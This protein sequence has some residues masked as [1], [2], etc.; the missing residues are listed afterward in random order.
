MKNLVNYL[1]ESKTINKTNYTQFVKNKGMG[2]SLQDWYKKEYK[3]DDLGDKIPNISFAE[4]LAMFFNE[5]EQFD[6]ECTVNDS[7][8]RERIFQKFSE[9]CKVKYDDFYDFWLKG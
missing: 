3:T 6:D 7:I 9:L 4:A 8:V 5:P 2:D 1:L